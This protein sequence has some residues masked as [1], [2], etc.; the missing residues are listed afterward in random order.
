MSAAEETTMTLNNFLPLIGV[1]VGGVIA[2]IGGFASNLF[3]EL[4]RNAAESKKLAYAFRGELCALASIVKKRAY[5]E[6]IKSMIT[7]M[8]QTKKPL[9]IQ[10]PIHREY[11]NVFNN[12]VS[13]IGSL[14][15]PLPELIARFYVQANSS[16]EDLQSYREG[17]WDNESVESIINSKKELVLL[18]EDN[19]A[20]VDEIVKQIDK[21]Y[22]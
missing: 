2:I 11:F 13:K 5:I 4:R 15:N 14:K 9:L 17:K 3:V 20:L 22:S 6:H 18:M 21:I 10:I 7:E 16:L 12:N 1:V 19:F 8:E